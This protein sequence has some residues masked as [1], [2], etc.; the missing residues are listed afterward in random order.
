MQEDDMI[1][2]PRCYVYRPRTF[3]KGSSKIEL[4]KVDQTKTN[5]INDRHYIIIGVSLFIIIFILIRVY[6]L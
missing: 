3:K 4:E 5:D 2:C 6:L 1:Q